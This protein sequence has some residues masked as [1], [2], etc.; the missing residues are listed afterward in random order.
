M[1]KSRLNLSNLFV[2]ILSGIVTAILCEKLVFMTGRRHYL[3][4]GTLRLQLDQRAKKMLKASRSLK[5]SNSSFFHHFWGLKEEIYICKHALCYF[6]ISI[7]NSL[8]SG[9]VVNIFVQTNLPESKQKFWKKINSNYSDRSDQD[10]SELWSAK[11]SGN[12]GIICH[13]AYNT[14]RMTQVLP[15]N[16]Q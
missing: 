6:S 12:N 5:R 4:L 13:Q 9:K 15:I 8:L 2:N 16:F 3:V 14:D 7:H 11:K 1:Q 10:A